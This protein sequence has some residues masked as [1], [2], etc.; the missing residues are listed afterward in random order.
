MLLTRFIKKWYSTGVLTWKMPL[1]QIIV[2]I[3]YMETSKKFYCSLVKSKYFEGCVVTL[4]KEQHRKKLL[5]ERRI[6]LTY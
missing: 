6:L 4:G 1:L 5:G 2:W 3:S